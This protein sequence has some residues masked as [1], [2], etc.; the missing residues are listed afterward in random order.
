MVRILG[1]RPGGPGSIPG[2]V[3]IFFALISFAFIIIIFFSTTSTWCHSN[4]HAASCREMHELTPQ[5]RRSV[6]LCLSTSYFSR[7]SFLTDDFRLRGHDLW[8]TAVIA[9]R[10]HEVCGGREQGGEIG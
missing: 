5:H 8:H 4:A 2:V 7:C 6:V 1:S 10:I 3:K 9:T